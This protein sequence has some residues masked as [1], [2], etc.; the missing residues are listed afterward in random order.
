MGGRFKREGIYMYLQLI[1][2]V[3]LQKLNIVKKLDSTF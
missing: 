2:S 1:H 3:V